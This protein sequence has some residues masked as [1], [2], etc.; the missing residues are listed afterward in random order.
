[1]KWNTSHDANRATCGGVNASLSRRNSK[2]VGVGLRI[3]LLPRITSSWV[4]P[5]RISE[6][7]GYET[8]YA[9]ATRTELFFVTLPRT[10][11]AD[12]SSFQ[13]N[14]INASRRASGV[15]FQ[16]RSRNAADP[17][18]F[19]P[20][21]FSFIKRA[22]MPLKISC[23][24]SPSAGTRI[25]AFVCRPAALTHSAA[26]QSHRA[27]HLPIIFLKDTG[28]KAARSQDAYRLPRRS[29]RADADAA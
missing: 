16:S 21:D 24:S 13:K 29:C 15:S 25:T 19:M 17:C 8:R 12:T 6:Y 2:T 23:Q 26:Q 5:V 11:P 28:K 4:R 3:S 27:T 22:S 10:M 18:S 7:P 14:G 20:A 9:F 1:M